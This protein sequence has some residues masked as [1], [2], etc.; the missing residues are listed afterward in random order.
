MLYYGILYYA[1]LYYAMLYYTMLY[2]T[3][4]V[5]TWKSPGDKTRN[6]IDYIMIYKRFKSALISTKT[7]PEAD[8]NSDYVPVVGKIKVK[9]KNITTTTIN[10]K[11]D[12]DLLRSNQ[13]IR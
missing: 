4:K 3:K 13:K 12:L 5:W 8:G 10:I 1:V 9:L 7:R 2:Y 11:L 6:S